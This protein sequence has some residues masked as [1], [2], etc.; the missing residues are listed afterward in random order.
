MLRYVFFALKI[1]IFILPSFVRK[2][3]EDIF[4]G[5]NEKNLARFH[6]VISK[7]LHFQFFIS[8]FFTA[9]ISAKILQD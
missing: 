2:S 9:A 3:E 6:L 4:V 1:T 5:G 8:G 7:N